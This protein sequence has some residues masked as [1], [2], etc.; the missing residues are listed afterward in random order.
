MP[1]FVPEFTM[2]RSRVVDR[3]MEV[4]RDLRK[5]HGIP[6]GTVQAGELSKGL[7]K[8]YED[9]FEVEMMMYEPWRVRK[10]D[11]EDEWYARGVKQYTPPFIESLD[12]DDFG[13]SGW[14]HGL[15][16]LMEVGRD[17][18]DDISVRL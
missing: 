16:T 3:R 8:Y 15:G 1:I 18:D 6:S 12:G 5:G 17:Y 10:P 4:M 7:E 13:P 14:H 2:S 11:R 9:A